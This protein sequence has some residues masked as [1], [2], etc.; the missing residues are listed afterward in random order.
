MKRRAADRN[1]ARAAGQPRRRAVGVAHDHVDAV[2]VDAE[3]VRYQLLVRGSETSAVFL[4][5]HDQLDA[6][7]V[8]EFDRR[9]L[10]KAA[11][12]AFGVGRH[13]DAAERAVALAAR[14]PLR[15]R[16]PLRRRHAAVHYLLELAG[17]KHELG[18][19]RVRHGRG[20]HEIDAADGVGAQLEFAR[21]G[22]D[23]ALKEIG[24][25]RPS[26]AAISAD[27]HRVGTHAFDVH[28]D[29]ADRVDAGD[30]IGRARRNE[31]A[32]RGKIGAHIGED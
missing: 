11:A 12:A 26:G 21:R 30:E 31:A 22:V 29:G 10:G 17:I 4:A 15:E 13:A 2:G 6:V 3:L 18:R 25:L 20:R 28:V 14:A 5:A 32:E 7:V 9:S 27:R 16:R 19:R 23:E 24:G 8:L 1:G